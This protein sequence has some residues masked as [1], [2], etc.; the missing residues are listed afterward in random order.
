MKG[1]DKVDKCR[2]VVTL[3]GSHAAKSCIFRGF[4]GQTNGTTFA[5]QKYMIWPQATNPGIEA[6]LARTFGRERSELL[7]LA[8]LLTGDRASSVDAVAAAMDLD[9]AGNPFF[10]NWMISWSRKLVIAK[11]LS[12]VEGE[13][14][15][16]AERTRRRNCPRPAELPGRRWSLDPA[17]GKVELERALLAVDLFPRCAVVLT[18][19][20]KVSEEDAAS[21]LNAD[22]QLLRT[23]KAV[24]LAELTWNLAQPQWQAASGL[25]S[26]P[27]CA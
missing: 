25:R 1:A 11:A 18:V 5:Y 8:Y 21:L 27:A 22:R 20:E 2:P 13:M 24:G 15:E 19:F 9:D 7:W 17:A 3:L 6:A 23:A 4:S 10:R 14:A 12:V 26:A 16:S